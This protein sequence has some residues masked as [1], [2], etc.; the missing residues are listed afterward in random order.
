MK[1][2]YV[3][4]GED[5]YGFWSNTKPNQLEIKDSNNNWTIQNKNGSEEE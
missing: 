5:H 1:T 2:A 4:G 3:I